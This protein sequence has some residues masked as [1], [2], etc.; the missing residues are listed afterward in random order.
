MLKLLKNCTYS[1]EDIN[2]ILT[3]K[4]NKYYIYNISYITVMYH[5]P[6]LNVQCFN[7]TINTILLV[8]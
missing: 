7:N 5:S 1:K 6:E 2:D 4:I 8:W 3:M